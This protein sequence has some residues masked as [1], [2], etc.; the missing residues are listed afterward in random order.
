MSRDPWADLAAELEAAASF[1]RSQGAAIEQRLYEWTRI[2]RIPSAPPPCGACGGPG[3]EDCKGTGNA[4]TMPREDGQEDRLV[5]R[6]LHF[7]RLTVADLAAR[8][9]KFRSFQQVAFPKQTPLEAKHLTTTQVEADGWC[10]SHWRIGE[11]VAI[12]T[13]PTGEPF[14]RGRCRRCGEWPE[15]DPPTEVLQTWKSG[16]SLR[17]AAS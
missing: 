12:S 1:A 11:F 6:Q 8:L 9:Q 17:V 4:P 14:Y 10:G 13:R 3:C 5:S 7:Y 16:R 2:G 15:G